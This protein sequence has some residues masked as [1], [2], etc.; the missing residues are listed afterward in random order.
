MIFHVF[1]LLKFRFFDII[2]FGKKSPIEMFLGNLQR[3]ETA[4]SATIFYF[5]NI[6][7]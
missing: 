1:Q 3:L 4:T 6:K 2:R 7:Y 5:D